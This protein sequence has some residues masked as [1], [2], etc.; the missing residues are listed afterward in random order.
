M[1]TLWRCLWCFLCRKER[2]W[3]KLSFG[4]RNKS[5]NY[6]SWWRYFESLLHKKCKCWI[7]IIHV[8][9]SNFCC[10]SNLQMLQLL[11]HLQHLPHHVIKTI[12]SWVKLHVLEIALYQVKEYTMKFVKRCRITSLVLLESWKMPNAQEK[13][14]FCCVN[15]KEAWFLT[16][17]KILD[18]TYWI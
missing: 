7:I 14:G 1:C 9:L 6:W 12:L 2:R 11:T 16:S 8:F 13:I 18:S 3:N 10:F 15:S 4:R 17:T 5:K